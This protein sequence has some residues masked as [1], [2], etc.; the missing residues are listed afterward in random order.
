MNILQARN[1]GTLALVSMSMKAAKMVDLI[2]AL[3]NANRTQ[4]RKRDRLL[5]R[6][7]V[8]DTVLEERENRWESRIVQR[9]EN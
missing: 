5:K 8:I 3:P 4:I 9:S 6:L 2:N 1:A 7:L